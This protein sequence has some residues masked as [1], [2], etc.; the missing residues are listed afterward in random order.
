MLNEV[1]LRTFTQKITKLTNFVKAVQMGFLIW[2]F[3]LRYNKTSGLSTD[4]LSVL[5]EPSYILHG[6]HLMGSV[7]RE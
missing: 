4:T 6:F 7:R 3:G 5:I 1:S 2:L